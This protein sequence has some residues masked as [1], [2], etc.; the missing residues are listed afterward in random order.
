VSSKLAVSREI[1]RFLR[2]KHVLSVATVPGLDAEI[3]EI[4]AAPRAPITYG[5]LAEIELPRGVL[6]GAVSRGKDVEIATG[7]TH[8]KVGDRA[9][10]FVLP[11]LVSEVEKLFSKP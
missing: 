7:E 11:R 9:I 10:V 1:L 3:L 8:V 5:T 6:V 4:E 2:G